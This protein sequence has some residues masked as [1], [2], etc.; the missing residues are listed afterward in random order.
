MKT[1]NAKTLPEREG[2]CL[3]DV[4]NICHFYK[5]DTVR[6][7]T[8]SITCHKLTL[9]VRFAK[10]KFPRISLVKGDS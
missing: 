4:K 3:T 9:N 7:L 5:R 6:A 8:V 10:G 2:T 1:S